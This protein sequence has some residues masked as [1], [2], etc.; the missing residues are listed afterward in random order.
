MTY[1]MEL[2]RDM[3][4]RKAN[5]NGAGWMVLGLG[6]GALA[7]VAVGMLFAPKAGCETREDIRSKAAETFDTIKNTMQKQAETAK[8]MAQDAADTV[9][10]A[11]N[12]ARKQA[13]KRIIDLRN[14]QEEFAKEMGGRTGRAGSRVN[15]PGTTTG[16]LAGSKK[17]SS[18]AKWDKSR[19]QKT[20][21]TGAALQN[22]ADS[23]STGYGYM[24]DSSPGSGYEE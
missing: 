14:T 12:D 17:S 4:W 7:G 10:K 15:V 5:G 11:A 8:G 3:G 1:A 18:N 24:Y 2:A 23:S 6:I 22:S 19:K 16:G 21:A 9:G 20:S 13:K